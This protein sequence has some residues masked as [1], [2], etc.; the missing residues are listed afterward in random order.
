M[1][2]PIGRIGVDSAAMNWIFPTDTAAHV[3]EYAQV[4]MLYSKLTNCLSVSNRL[5]CIAL[6]VSERLTERGSSEARL[7]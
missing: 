4:S 2:Y 3:A 1:P 5:L 6:L 7:P